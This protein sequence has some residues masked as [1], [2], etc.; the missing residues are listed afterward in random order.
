[1]I[2]NSEFKC[3]EFDVP[4]WDW[5]RRDWWEKLNRE[6]KKSREGKK[7]RGKQKKKKTLELE[8]E[9]SGRDYTEE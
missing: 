2:P 3:E 5:S 7:R 4:I 6:V 8:M 1:M 9:E